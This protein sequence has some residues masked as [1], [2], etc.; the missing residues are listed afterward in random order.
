M[1]RIFAATVGTPYALRGIAFML[2]LTENYFWLTE[3]KVNLEPWSNLYDVPSV[4]GNKCH[5]D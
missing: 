5:M 4:K 1:L 2:K 3:E